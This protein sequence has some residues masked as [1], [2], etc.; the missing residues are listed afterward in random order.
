M[1]IDT[2]V[3]HYVKTRNEIKE[4]EAKIAELKSY[5]EKKEEW[6][7][8]QLQSLGVESMRS[9]HGT[10]YQT[11]FE[12]CTVADRE[13][14]MKWVIDNQAFNFLENRVAKSEAL[15]YMGDREN[16]A[17]PNPPPPGIN[18]TAIKKI[19]IRKG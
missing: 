15:N 14:F 17:R 10:V 7:N 8:Q 16:N 1:N 6:L 2:V 9:S 5:Q 11:T 19:G 13:V 12:S 3:E 18:Y 4:L